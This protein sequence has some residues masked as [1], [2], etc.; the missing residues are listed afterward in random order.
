[1]STPQLANRVIVVVTVV[2]VTSFVV[3]IVSPGYRA[4][5]QIHVVFLAALAALWRSSAGRQ[6]SDELL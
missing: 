5:P 3:S 1:M 6:G 4:D 2:W